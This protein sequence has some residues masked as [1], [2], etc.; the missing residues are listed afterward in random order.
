MTVKQSILWIHRWLGFISGLVV[1][2]V[3]AT[4]CLFVFQDDIQ[5]ALYSYRHVVQQ[6]RPYVPPSQLK[7]QALALYPGGKAG[8]RIIYYGPDRPAA[9]TVTTPKKESFALYFNP[10]NGKLLHTENP[11]RNFF[12]IVEFI[13]LYLLLPPVIGKQVVGISVIIFVILMITGIVLWWPKRKKDV[14]RSLT[15]KWGARW[16]R[17]NY[18]LHNVLGFYAC[19]VALILALTGLSFAYDWMHTGIYQATNLGR[20]FPDDKPPAKLKTPVDS[21]VTQLPVDAAFAYSVSH[22]PQAQMFFVSNITVTA[23]YKSMRFYLSD[24]Y[25]FNNGGGLIQFLPQDSK[26]PGMKM[27]DANYDLHTGQILGLF[28]KIIAFLASLISAS[29]PIT[30]LMVWVGKRNKKGKKLKAAKIAAS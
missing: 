30:G 26:S 12:I 10:Y 1:F 16:R 23:Y 3:S 11:A 27:N 18:D 4:G 15:I 6:N 22:S 29:L 28:G 14:K 20:G 24:R 21:V 9:I 2:V 7:K 19:A 5:D 8:V 17:V 25:T 13:H